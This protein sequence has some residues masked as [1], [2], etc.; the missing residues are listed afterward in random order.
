MR[1]WGREN[2]EGKRKGKKRNGKIEIKGKH[3][4]GS[5]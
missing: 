5:T 1:D 3:K 2:I 4:R